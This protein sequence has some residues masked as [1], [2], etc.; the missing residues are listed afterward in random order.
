MAPTQ[1]S[2]K[3]K[4][5]AMKPQN[6]CMYKLMKNLPMIGVH[7]KIHIVKDD[8]NLKTTLRGYKN[9]PHLYHFGEVDLFLNST[10]QHHLT[11]ISV[12]FIEEG[13]CQWKKFQ[14]QNVIKREQLGTHLGELTSSGEPDL[15]EIKATPS[16]VESPNT[17]I[18]LY[19]IKL[20][21]NVVEVLMSKQIER[22]R[23]TQVEPY[24]NEDM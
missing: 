21:G 18:R 15:K 9:A 8:V 12:N 24:L 2:M 11:G 7:P 20:V 23:E 6:S 13:K 19:F 1:I 10:E 4:M 16:E 5:N 14:S 3:G 17:S 22:L